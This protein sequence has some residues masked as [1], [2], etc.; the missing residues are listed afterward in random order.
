MGSTDSNFIQT[1]VRSNNKKLVASGDDDR[2]VNIYNYPC[3]SDNQK[4]KS[5]QYYIYNFSGHSEPVTKLL[6]NHDDTKLISFAGMDKSI[7]IWE[8][9]KQTE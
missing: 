5:Y 3:L 7:I 9:I 4:V 2:F 8:I 1:V 6:F